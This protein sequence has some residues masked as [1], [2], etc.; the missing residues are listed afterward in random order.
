MS[1]LILILTL[2]VPMALVLGA[3]VAGRGKHGGR[4]PRFMYSPG[5]HADKAAKKRSEA[6]RALVH[7]EGR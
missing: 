7:G 2:I 5:N 4:P 6:R 3:A 1:P